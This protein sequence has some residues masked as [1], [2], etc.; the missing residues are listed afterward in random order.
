MQI[1]LRNICKNFGSTS[2]NSDISII[3][4]A[5]A[6]HGIV[7]ENGAGKST[8]VKI[9]SGY[10]AKSGGDILIDQ[11]PV[12]LENPSQALQLGIGM[13]FQDPMDFPQL[14][15][16]DNY[17][18]GLHR[19]FLLRRDFFRKQ[20]TAWCKKLGFTFY[21]DDRLATLSIAERH[22]LELI[23]LLSLGVQVL[24]LD[25]P[26]TGTSTV[27]KDILFFA[28][29]QLAESGK[30]IILVSHKLKDVESLC[31][32]VSV[33][34]KG[35]LVCNMQRPFSQK[36][37]LEHMFEESPSTPRFSYSPSGSTILE[38]KQVWGS[39]GRNRLIN[40]SMCAC[41]GDIIG[42]AGIQNS[43]QELFLRIAAG[44]AKADSGQIRLYDRRLHHFSYPYLKRQGVAFVP[45]AR[46]E[47]GLISGLTIAE[48]TALVQSPTRFIPSQ[49]EIYSKTQ[50][51]LATFDIRGFPDTSVE[52]LSGGNQQRLLFS[53]I[54]LNSIVLLLE[55]PTR[56]L[57]PASAAYIWNHL[58]NAYQTNA[59]IIFSSWDLDELLTYSNRLL[60]FFDGHIIK[61][62]PTSQI[63]M[64]QLSRAMAGIT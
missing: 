4:K 22:Q 53:F 43:G 52:M 44:L 55:N 63:D 57:D 24:I 16:F 51:R 11:T 5:A 58:L 36:Q 38:F 37:L 56:G 26:T 41:Q 20:L 39:K 13:L 27:Q 61:D 45:S 7:G 9:I 42:L 62:V 3:F 50:G 31:T 12:D 14:S 10:T 23:R 1:E 15:V 2:A 21:P 19:A 8:L 28:L 46:L 49:P 30:T 48:H 47:E 6:I 25:E 17:I 59:C 18:L 32:H 60:V 34:R 54:P 33:L 64:V 40:C 35:R 29:Q